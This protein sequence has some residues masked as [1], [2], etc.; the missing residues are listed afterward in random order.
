MC[1]IRRQKTAGD[2]EG[3]LHHQTNIAT[4]SPL[5]L[6]LDELNSGAGD[7]D[8][9]VSTSATPLVLKPTTTTTTTADFHSTLCFVYRPTPASTFASRNPR[10]I[11]VPEQYKCLRDDRTQPYLNFRLPK[12]QSPCRS[13]QDYEHPTKNDSTHCLIGSHSDA[14]LQ[15]YD[16]KLSK[17]IASPV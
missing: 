17:T 2:A 7:P 3:R 12:F 15:D 1:L 5:G 8:V 4:T 16:D 6:G 10:E 14:V 9:S 13:A 11:Q